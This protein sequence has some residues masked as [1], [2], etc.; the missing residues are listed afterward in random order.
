[1]GS[2]NNNWLTEGLIDFEYKK[3]VLM[4]YFQQVKENFNEK[5]LYPHLSDLIFHYQNLVSI[6]E[7]KK[8]LQEHF[9]SVITKAD[10]DSLT[11]AYEKMVQDDELMNELE[12]IISFSLPLF[13]DY[14]AEG[15]D[16]YE[17]LESK[18]EIS[19]VGLSVLYP[20]EGYLFLNQYSTTETLIYEYRMTIF[21]QAQ[22]KYRG[23]HLNYIETK[24]KSISNTY[25]SMKFA[26]I[27]QNQTMPN[28]ATYLIQAKSYA[29]LNETILP[30]AKRVLVKYIS[31]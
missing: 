4:A 17:Y 11:L 10:F 19:P 31:V 28:P 15:R 1:M 30:I 6:K 26:L 2:L 20:E 25:E 9:P 23:I 29:P 7:N 14:M 22:E 16:L 5:K 18:M 13:K 3:Y 12:N 21:T 8:L 27:K 24:S